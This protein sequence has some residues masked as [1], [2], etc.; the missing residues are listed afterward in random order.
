MFVAMNRFQI[1]DGRGPDFERMWRERESHLESVPGFVQFALL[2]GDE[3]GDYISHTTWTSRE[4]FMTWAQSDA[5][6]QAH[7]SRPAE[8]VMA[9]HPRAAFYEAVLV[10]TPP[11]V[12]RT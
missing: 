12:A 2:K 7:S 10:E 1:A 8:G 4:A 11:E 5:F 9:G 6:R 3:P